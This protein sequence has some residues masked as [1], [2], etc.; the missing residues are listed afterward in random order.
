[1]QPTTD[2]IGYVA[3]DP[4]HERG[5]LTNPQL[6]RLGHFPDCSHH[7]YK[8]ITLPPPSPLLALDMFH[9]CA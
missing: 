5:K 9:K 1:M 6:R 7:P 4:I 8:Q 2:F 3:K